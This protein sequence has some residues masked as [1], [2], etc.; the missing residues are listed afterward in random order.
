MHDGFD[1]DSHRLVKEEQARKEKDFRSAR[2]RLREVIKRA[3][4][5]PQPEPVA[6][7]VRS[8]ASPYVERLESGAPRIDY[9]AIERN[10][11]VMAKVLAFQDELR[12][13]FQ[14]RMA[15]YE[16]DEDVALLTLWT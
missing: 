12:S 14:A 1:E 6:A 7:Q 9:A 5:G 13:E 10:K 8:L 3:W 4:D 16:D 11:T 2:S 15:A